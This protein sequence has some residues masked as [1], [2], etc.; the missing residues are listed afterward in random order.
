MRVL[1]TGVFDILHPGHIFLL[2]HAAKLGEVMVIIARD[3]TVKKW[4]KRSPAVPELQRLAVI[5][6]IKYVSYA[7]LGNENNNFLQ[8]AL[9]L[10]PDIIFLGPNQRIKVSQLKAKLEEAGAGNVEVRRLKTF[11]DEYPLTSSTQ[12]KKKIISQNS[13]SSDQE[14]SSS[15]DFE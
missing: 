5:Q 11:F 15:I 2:E 13:D 8:K 4:K 9:S 14:Y 6:A 12:I 7:T 3:S 1:V 10:K